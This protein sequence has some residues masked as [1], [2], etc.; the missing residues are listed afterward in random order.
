M[1]SKPRGPQ[2]GLPLY[3]C[4]VCST[5]FQPYRESQ[6][7]CSPKCRNGL[8]DKKQREREYR[9]QPHVRK[10]R[11]ERRN[12]TNDP[13]YKL[14]NRRGALRKYGL[15]IEEHEQMLAAQDGKCAIC[16]NP[17]KPDGVRAASRLHV[18]HDHTTGKVRALLCNH[19]N[20]GLG[21]FGDNPELLTL[22]ATYLREHLER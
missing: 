20:R 10:R 13:S 4:E 22:A 3:I 17:P 12:I 19:C 6:R 16:G 15:T 18:D 2:G 5:L 14:K 1:A 11:S 21:A 7:I 9:Q 8:P